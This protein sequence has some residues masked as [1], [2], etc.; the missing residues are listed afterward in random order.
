MRLSA[1]L[2]RP[3]AVFALSVAL[4]LGACQ[5][6]PLPYARDGELPSA[7]VV[8]DASPER[9]ALNAEVFDTVVS[10]VDRLYYDPRMG[11]RDWTALTGRYRSDVLA[12]TTEPGLYRSLETM[13]KE[14]DDRHTSVTSPAARA[15]KDRV[16]RQQD[17]VGYGMTVIEDDG[18]F[19]VTRLRP[20]GAAAQA[21]VQIGWRVLTWNAQS[22]S[23]TQIASEDRTDRIVFRDEEDR[24]HV[25]DLT[26]RT[27]PPRP[28][29]EASRRDDGILVLRFDGFDGASH[30]WM[31]QQ[32]DVLAADPP[33]AVIVDLRDNPGGR[34]DILADMVA[35]VSADRVPF[36]VMLGRFIDRRYY[37][38]RQPKAWTG[39]LAVLI[40]P[41][42]GSA[43]ELFAAAMQEQKRGPV[44]G[45]TTA[46][47]VIGSRQLN[48]PDGGELSVS[49]V[50]ILTSDRTLLE[51]VGVTPD[52]PTKPTL[53]DL[54]AG[55]DPTLIAAIA[56]LNLPDTAQAGS[57]R[58]QALPQRS[59][60]TTTLP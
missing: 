53:E 23:R 57:I 32:L 13:L 1:T 28:Q 37:T 54:R 12:Q 58:S 51:K 14:L 19:T 27:L 56:A 9:E 26:G 36:A 8:P 22:P 52:V 45:Q 39:P 10:L 25:L 21:G 43:S 44:V 20:D 7:V 24:E 16:D 34:F 49:T 60:K 38:V 59:S 55:R 31:M 29:R 41:G 48:L 18:V 46:G 2:Q 3:L 42:S 6:T 17:T 5:T 4:A 30:D 40:G 15:I 11:G 50:A 47:A 35:A 33:K